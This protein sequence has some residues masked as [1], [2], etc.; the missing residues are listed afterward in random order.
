MQ[1]S[2]KAGV[3]VPAVKHLGQG[4]VL[5]CLLALVA[6]FGAGGGSLHEVSMPTGVWMAPGPIITPPPL[7]A[8]TNGTIHIGDATS[9]ALATTNGTLHIGG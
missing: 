5:L 2:M 9:P 3:L 6:L 1:S 7:M 4:V 8:T